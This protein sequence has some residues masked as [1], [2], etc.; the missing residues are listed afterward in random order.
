MCVLFSITVID[1]TI[2]GYE[3]FHWEFI[4]IDK[5]NK[6]THQLLTTI[7]FCGKLSVPPKTIIQFSNM[8]MFVWLDCKQ[9]SNEI[10]CTIKN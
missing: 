1:F 10:A 4:E 8:P 7:F 3:S 5:Y 6:Q 9:N 2:I